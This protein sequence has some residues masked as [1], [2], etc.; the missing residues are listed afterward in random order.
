MIPESGITTYAEEQKRNPGTLFGRVPALIVSYLFH[1]VLIPVYVV[2]FLIYWHP[3]VAAGNNTLQ[4]LFLLISVF[5][6]CTLLPSISVLLMWRLKLIRS[7]FLNTQ[8]ERLIPYA[9]AMIFYFWSW[10]VLNHERNV[11]EEVKLFLLGSFISVIAAWLA[12]IYF[13]I[14]IHALA[15]SG[16]AFFV[17]EIA[18]TG[19]GSPGQYLSV[20]W[21]IVGVVCSARLALGHHRPFEIYAGIILG[22]ASQVIAML[23]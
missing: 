7:V 23:I 22:I 2:L 4:K 15:V 1:P 18:L 14:S 12:N 6:N 8:K 9:A 10:Y 21:L 16:M 5:V 11:P 3:L 17:S 13:K 20:A 19:E